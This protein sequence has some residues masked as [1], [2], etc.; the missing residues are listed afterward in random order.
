MQHLPQTIDQ[1]SAGNHI[2]LLIVKIPQHR[3]CRPVRRASYYKRHQQSHLGMHMGRDQF[4]YEH[5]EQA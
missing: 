4:A 1:L 5:T 3:Q 2:Q